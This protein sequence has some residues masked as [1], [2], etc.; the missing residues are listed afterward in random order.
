MPE[1]SLSGSSAKGQTLRLLRQPSSPKTLLP[2]GKIFGPLERG[3][4]LE[5][6]NAQFRIEPSQARHGVLRFSI[7][8]G[9]RVARRERRYCKPM[10]GA[11]VY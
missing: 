10:A 2:L 1:K 5:I 4:F 11:P 7:T 9:I 3:Q 6:G 8:S